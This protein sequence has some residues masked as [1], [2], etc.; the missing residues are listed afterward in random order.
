MLFLKKNWEIQE[1]WQWSH[2][3][4]HVQKWGRKI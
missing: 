4:E 2:L 1:D 3:K